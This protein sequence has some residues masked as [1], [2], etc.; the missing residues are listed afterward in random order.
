M[1]PAAD[2]FAGTSAHLWL[3]ADTQLHNFSGKATKAKSG[4]VDKRFSSVA[5]RP[6]SLDIWSEAVLA[7]IVEKMRTEDPASPVFFLGDAADVS[8]TGEYA[9]FLSLMQPV[10][11]LGVPGNHDG[12]YMGN[13]TFNA[14]PSPARINADGTFPPRPLQGLNDDNTWLGACEHSPPNG[15]QGLE[16]I[17]RAFVEIDRITAKEA[18][19][20]AAKERKPLPEK[21]RTQGQVGI[22]T[23][24]NSIWLYLGDLASRIKLVDEGHPWRPGNWKP[25][26]GRRDPEYAMEGSLKVGSAQIHIKARALVSARTKKEGAP[27]AWQAFL[28]QDVTLP[29]GVHALLIDTSDYRNMLTSLT[30]VFGVLKARAQG[31]R[32]YPDSR[33][34]LPGDC[35]EVSERQGA[36]IEELMASWPPGTRFF[37]MGH[38]P[39]DTLRPDAEKILSRLRAKPEFLTYISAHSHTATAAKN[40]DVAW[41]W[42]INVASTTDWPMEYAR[43]RYQPEEPAAKGSS[44]E[45][46]VRYVH[47]RAQCPYKNEPSVAAAEEAEADYGFIEN[48]L[49]RALQVYR[50][51]WA[52]AAAQQWGGPLRADVDAKLGALD[53][54]HA[55]FRDFE[56]RSRGAGSDRRSRLEIEGPKLVQEQRQLLSDTA[57][58]D[59]TFRTRA[60]ELIELEAAC[61]IWASEVEC[62]K[63]KRGCPAEKARPGNGIERRTFS[64]RIPPGIFPQPKP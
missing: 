41:P 63:K 40:N 1:T 24:A 47:S 15:T 45:L 11:W 60:P 32:H 39:W 13:G 26:P 6:P 22:L 49:A 35:G 19:D 57:I 46:D 51:L 7:S 53:A 58:L 9:R 12:F 37:V 43:L 29:S 8:C 64:F 44:F 38:H 59:R 34:S 20:T 16:E 25:V 10:P 33:I 5:I 56:K 42:E 21:R 61:A 30:Q 23:K 2:V 55:S 50:K 48:Y 36:L 17:E 54:I 27:Q 28:L 14:V 31:C 18:A 4:I 62:S 52:H 3:L